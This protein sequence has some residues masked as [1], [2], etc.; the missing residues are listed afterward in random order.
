MSLSPR[1]S[2]VTIVYND[3]SHIESTI[4]SVI[5]QSYLNVEYII[6]DGKS[7]DGTIDIVQKYMNQID[8]LKSESDT[9]LYDAMNKGLNTATGDYVLFLN[10]GDKLYHSN[11]LQEIV[12]QLRDRLPDVIYGETM[13]I[14]EDGSEIGLRRLK[15]PETLTWKS[16]K[17]GMLVCHQSFLVKRTIAPRYNLQYKL[18]ADYDWMLNVLRKSDY[19]VSTHKIISAFL[20]GSISKKN[21]KNSLRERF[22]IMVKNYGWLPVIINHVKIGLR[23]TIYYAK[24]KRF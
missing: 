20:D 5:G 15:A 16:L 11:I 10:S 2:I 21:I 6:I 3:S 17:D 7:S 18:S 8:H 12:D 23:F 24:N 9:G 14:A 19:I 4:L 22:K 1:V 13:I